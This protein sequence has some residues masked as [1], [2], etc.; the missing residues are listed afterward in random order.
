MIESIESIWLG[1]CSRSL[2]VTKERTPPVFRLS[3]DSLRNKL[4]PS[5]SPEIFVTEGASLLSS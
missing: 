5:K 4:W 3:M 1:F 2:D